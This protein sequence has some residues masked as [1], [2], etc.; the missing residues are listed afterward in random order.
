[1][2]RLLQV[3]GLVALFATAGCIGMSDGLLTVAGRLPSQLPSQ[4]TLRLA[5]P[6]EREPSL[7]NTRLIAQE[8][9][10]HFTV[11]PGWGNYRITILCPGFQT[12][13]KN[14]RSRSSITRVDL[15]AIALVPQ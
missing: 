2:R 10:E 5:L 6:D 3:T 11:A 9:I 12:L 7:Y 4:C 13:E 14:V 8:F 1:M 15:G